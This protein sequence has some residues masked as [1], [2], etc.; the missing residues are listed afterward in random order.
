MPTST[1]DLIFVSLENWDDIWRRNQFIC[2]EL[3][4]RHPQQKILFVGL[5]HDVSHAVRSGKL[6]QVK[7]VAPCPVPGF[8]N[9]FFFR[10][11]KWWPNTL[12]KGR[13][14]NEAAFRRQVR[15][16]A[17]SLQL[18]R[19]VLWIN[20]HSALHMAGEMSEVG[21]VYD[22]TDDWTSANQPPAVKQLITEQDAALCRRADATIVCSQRLFE[23]KLPLAKRL[24][25]VPNGVDT[26]H[27]AAVADG[28]CAPDA[29]TVKWTHPVLGY[30][31]T[32]HPERVDV[33]LVESVARAFPGGTVALVGPNLLGEAEISRLAALKNVVLTGAVSYRSVPHFLTAF[34]VCL[35]P[36]LESE[37]TES[38]NPIK[39][40][41]YLAT[42]KPVVSTD[43]AGFR[44]FAHLCFI[45]SG[46]QAFIEACKMA[47]EE[48]DSRRVA[49][50]QAAAQNSWVAR[51][52][53]IEAILAPFS[54]D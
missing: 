40:W 12:G 42:G 22:I 16:A 45:A 32:V 44:D 5:P 14:A 8:P 7:A 47:L 43:V 3:A 1:R 34:D 6:A 9:I 23:M 17:R 38:L 37:F 11:V 10:P 41:E 26:A 48:N 4:R 36:H 13:K 27:Y 25:L 29:E 53:Q 46:S 24:F 2:A 20:P 31:G 28:T 18:T 54:G 49:R 21:V 50:L 30:V 51:V 19:P 15:R 52:D 35:V 39:L 33:A